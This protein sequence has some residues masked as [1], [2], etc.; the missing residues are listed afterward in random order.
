M[1]LTKT[2]IVIGRQL[3]IKEMISFA[4]EHLEAKE[5]EITL[6]YCKEDRIYKV[7]RNG[8]SLRW[9]RVTFSSG[10]YNLVQL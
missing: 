9:Y 1:S 10:T 2:A 3:S 5:G 6:E 7:L 8:D 4:T